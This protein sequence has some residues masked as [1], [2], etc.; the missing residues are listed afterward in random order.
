MAQSVSGGSDF[1]LEGPGGGD[2]E[3]R[4]V[5]QELLLA[6]FALL[7][8]LFRPVLFEARNV[9]QL[10]NAIEATVLLVLFLRMW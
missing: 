3:Q 7:T 10:V 8:A 4:S 5:F 6:P 9:V 1:Q 2:V